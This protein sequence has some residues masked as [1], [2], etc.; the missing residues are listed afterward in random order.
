MG[1]V[2]TNQSINSSKDISVYRDDGTVQRISHCESVYITEET[3]AHEQCNVDVLFDIT[4]ANSDE[5]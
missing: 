1:V 4:K 2:V 5:G 3:P